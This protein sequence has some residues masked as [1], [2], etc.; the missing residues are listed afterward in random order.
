MRNPAMLVP[1]I[2]L[3]FVLGYQYDMAK[4]NKMDRII[5]K[6]RPTSLPCTRYPLMVVWMSAA[7]ADRILEKEQNLVA[8]PGPPL[9][10]QLIEDAIKKSKGTK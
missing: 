7:E 5:G 4:G 8:L 9:T 3:S 6:S 2:P 10:T 1:L